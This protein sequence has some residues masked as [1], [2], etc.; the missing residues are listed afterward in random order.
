MLRNGVSNRAIIPS[1]MVRTN[2]RSDI[3]IKYSYQQACINRNSSKR[4]MFAYYHITI[5][6][7]I[8]LLF[9]WINYEGVI[10]FFELEYFIKKFLCATLHAC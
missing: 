8:V 6:S 7:H 9:D 2:C 1:K 3:Q 5:H 10:A 4:C